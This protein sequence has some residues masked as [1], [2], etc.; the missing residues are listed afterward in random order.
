MLATREMR[1]GRMRLTEAAL[2]PLIDG[3]ADALPFTAIVTQTWG[4]RPGVYHLKEHGALSAVNAR[5]RN[6]LSNGEF[7]III[8]QHSKQNAKV[9]VSHYVHMG[10]H[11]IGCECGGKRRVRHRTCGKKRCVCVREGCGCGGVGHATTSTLGRPRGFW[12]PPGM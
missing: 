2:K 4:A 12:A 5:M 8:R 10:A 1:R 7:P 11:T 6:Q 9:A 3:T